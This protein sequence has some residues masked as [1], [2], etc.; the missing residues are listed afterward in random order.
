M[1]IFNDTALLLQIDLANGAVGI[2]NNSSNQQQ[3]QQRRASFTGTGTERYFSGTRRAILRMLGEAGT[4]GGGE[5]R[6]EYLHL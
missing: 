5:V 1:H 3:Q 4:R 6:K 2:L